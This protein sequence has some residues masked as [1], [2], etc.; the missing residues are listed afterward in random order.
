MSQEQTREELLAEFEAASAALLAVLPRFTEEQWF[1]AE[2]NDGW[3]VHDIVAHI[4]D[5]NYA[6][7]LM[8]LGQLTPPRPLNE[9]TGWMDDIDSINQ[10]RREKNASLPREKVL[11]R[12]NK[13]LAQVRSTIEQIE[14]LDGPGPFGPQITRRQILQRIVRH[15]N[16]HCSELEELL[17]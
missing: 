3:R 16:E 12:T 2:R 13:A 7:A 17:K 10:E 14:D 5:S 8:A 1:A 9:Q 11:D 6:L 4:S 15:I